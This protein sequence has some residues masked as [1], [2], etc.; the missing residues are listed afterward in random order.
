MDGASIGLA[1]RYCY[2]FWDICPLSPTEGRDDR[3]GAVCLDV[4]RAILEIPHEACEES[5]L[6]GLGEW[7]T[8][9]PT[10]VRQAIDAFLRRRR[11][12]ISPA[13]LAF[14]ERRRH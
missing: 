8:A 10:A 1:N 7:A 13:L 9:N 12:S 2:M 5:A 14:A 6:H 4:M 11:V 3:R